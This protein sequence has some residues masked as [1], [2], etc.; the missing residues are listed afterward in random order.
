MNWGISP[1]NFDDVFLLLEMNSIVKSKDVKMSL[2]AAT[3]WSLWLTRNAMVF[4]EKLIYS[5]L[6][7]PFQIISLMMQWKPLFHPDQRQG[8]E[9]LM[10]HLRETVSG[11]RSRSGIG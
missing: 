2:I 7:I 1:R 3:A 6:T 8:L 5:P 9:L 11:L 10:S 4:R